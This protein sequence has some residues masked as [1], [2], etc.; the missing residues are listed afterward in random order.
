MGIDAEPIMSKPILS[1]TLSEFW[2][3]RWNLGFRQLAHDFISS[4]A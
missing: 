1:R 4:P 3:K 2:S